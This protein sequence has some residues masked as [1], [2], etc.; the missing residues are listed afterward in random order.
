MR[1]DEELLDE[2]E[3]AN[4]GEG[5]DPIASFEGAA[6][7]DLLAAVRARA[8]AQAEIDAAVAQARA[9]G[10]SWSTIGAMLG[11]SRQAAFK[12]YASAA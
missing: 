10:A 7:R 6:L 11:I 12:K 2:I 3:N 8:L 1:T 9:Q 4:D 5:P